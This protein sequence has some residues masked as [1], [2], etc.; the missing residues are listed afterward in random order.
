MGT[1]WDNQFTSFFEFTAN[2]PLSQLYYYGSTVEY[3][4]AP[5]DW[6]SVGKNQRIKMSRSHS[7]ATTQNFNEIVQILENCMC[8]LKKKAFFTHIHVILGV[9]LPTS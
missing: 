8:K 5:Y 7:C 9:K 3:L 6:F 2:L 1:I 4:N